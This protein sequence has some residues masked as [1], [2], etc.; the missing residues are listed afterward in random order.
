MGRNKQSAGTIAILVLMLGALLLTSLM[1]LVRPLDETADNQN[2]NE[3]TATVVDIDDLPEDIKQL[4]IGGSTATS[5]PTSTSAV[6]TRQ[7]MATDKDTIQTRIV[8]RGDAIRS[9]NEQTKIKQLVLDNGEEREN[10]GEIYMDIYPQVDQVMQVLGSETGEPIFLMRY[11]G[12]IYR[13]EG[14]T[15]NWKPYQPESGELTVIPYAFFV[16]LATHPLMELLS[17]SPDEMET[18]MDSGAADRIVLG[19]TGYDEGILAEVQTNYGIELTG[20]PAEEITL[21]V[22]VEVAP[23]NYDILMVEVGL[24]AEHRD[25]KVDVTFSTTL[26]N[27]NNLRELA[28][29]E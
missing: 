24:N 8:E 22:R 23:N 11:K 5:P 17:T 2:R 15:E 18:Q 13:S 25:I 9:Y 21:S 20:F 1:I 4:L 6:P 19:W 12:E 16:E 3:T 29:P 28:K 14:D 7:T 26:S 27:H 10:N